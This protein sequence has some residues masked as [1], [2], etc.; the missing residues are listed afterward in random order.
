MDGGGPAR[1]AGPG[2]RRRRAG[3]SRRR[4]DPP[5]RRVRPPGRLAAR[6]CPRPGAH[7]GG[8]GP[9]G[10]PCALGGDAVARRV[11][12]RRRECRPHVR[13]LRPRPGP[14]PGRR[15][16]PAL[17][18][19]GRRPA[20]GADHRARR[21]RRVRS[22]MWVAEPRRAASAPPRST[23]WPAPPR[24]RC[25][26]FP[27]TTSAG[28]GWTTSS[29]SSR[30]GTRSRSSSWWGDRPSATRW[31]LRPVVL[32]W[33]ASIVTTRDEARRRGDGHARQRRRG[34]RRPRPRPGHRRS[35]W[36]R[37][38]VGRS[39]SARS[40]PA[41]PRSSG[42]PVSKRPASGAR[43]LERYHGP[44]GLD[45]GARSPAESAV[46]IVAEILAVR[47]GRP[48]APLG[49]TAGRIGG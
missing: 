11:A 5:G 14:A 19:P 10:R 13:R 39:T 33:P 22:P 3:P 29:S 35:S 31:W 46:S 48:A 34:G 8:H 40:A 23:T 28:P 18:R 36:R 12:R 1:R 30:R 43:R 2:D 25:W 45:L 32:G 7:L 26:R 38:K 9:A 37:C 41:T 15:A 21:G 24:R 44:T 47:S 42:W 6:R 49:R 20:R 27:A 16:G 4:R 17:G